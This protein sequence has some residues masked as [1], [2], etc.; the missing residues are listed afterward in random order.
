MLQ[1]WAQSSFPLQQ[2]WCASAMLKREVGVYILVTWRLLLVE[3]TAHCLLSAVGWGGG[4]LGSKSGATI[5]VAHAT[6]CCPDA[7][8][9]RRNGFFSG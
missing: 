2:Y 5:A 8:V 7:S 1:G 4:G 6:A 9:I 3:D